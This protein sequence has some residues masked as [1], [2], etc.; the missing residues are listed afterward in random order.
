MEKGYTRIERY[1]CNCKTRLYGKREA[2]GSAR[3]KCP[4][5][6]VVIFSRLKSR[7]QEVL[8]I[9]APYDGIA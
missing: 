1:C 3:L 5:C 2:D 6:G 7:R 4:T 8:N 9:Y